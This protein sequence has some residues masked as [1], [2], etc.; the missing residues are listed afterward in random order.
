MNKALCFTTAVS[1]LPQAADYLQVAE[2]SAEDGCYIGSAPPLLSQSCHRAKAEMA[3][4]FHDLDEIVEENLRL[5]EEDGMP[6][7]SPAEAEAYGSELIRS[8]GEH[9][10]RCRLLDAAQR[11]ICDGIY[12]NL[13]QRRLYFKP[14][15]GGG[16]LR[17]GD[18]DSAAYLHFGGSLTVGIGGLNPLKNGS[19]QVIERPAGASP[20][21]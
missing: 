21:A 14:L 13:G 9:I 20:E 4:L 17:S 5:L 12:Q 15:P 1:H 19:F 6:I 18:R 11:P 7:P 8:P 3:G 10:L 16:S 2:W